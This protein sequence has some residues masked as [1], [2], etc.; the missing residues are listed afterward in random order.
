MINLNNLNIPYY[1]KD[2]WNNFRT[3][4]FKKKIPNTIL[5]ISISNIEKINFIYCLISLM[6]CSNHSLLCNNCYN[7]KL[8]KRKQHPDIY[9]LNNHKELITID[10]IRMLQKFAFIYPYINKYKFIVIE[11]IE[12]I[13]IYAKNALLKLLEEPPSYLYIILSSEIVGI[14]P[15]TIL[16]RCYKYRLNFPILLRYNYLDLNF[17]NNNISY[18]K[19]NILTKVNIFI[20]DLQNLIKNKLYICNFLSK[21]SKYNFYDVIWMIYLVNVQMICYHFKGINDKKW[22]KLI[23]LSEQFSIDFLFKQLDRIYNL[24]IKYHNTYGVNTNFFLEYIILSYV[25]NY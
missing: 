2:I 24:M 14:I 9:T 8:I 5:F 7:C 17:W 23:N 25:N 12:T 21:W 16:S 22:D 3:L 20:D 19:R 10:H 15:N 4:F 13:N 6:L 1:N 11:Y 18:E